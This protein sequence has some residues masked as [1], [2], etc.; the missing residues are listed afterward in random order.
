MRLTEL[1]SL[2]SY[3]EFP[4]YSSAL[5]MIRLI[6][7]SIDNDLVDPIRRHY[8]MVDLVRH[9]NAKRKRKGVRPEVLLDMLIAAFPELETADEFEREKGTR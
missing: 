9:R 2:P 3:I 5:Y 4:C 7:N 1:A 8:S 6:R